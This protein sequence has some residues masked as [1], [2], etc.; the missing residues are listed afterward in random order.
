[1]AEKHKTQLAD[2]P[3]TYVATSS[4]P[5]GRPPSATIYL[6]GL[7]CLCFD[8]ANSC[9]VA[10][11]EA[12][13][14]LLTFGVW[15]KNNCETVDL[16]SLGAFD[17]LAINV[18]RSG[19][20]VKGVNVYNGA[21]FST[22]K[23]GTFPDEDRW[24]YVDHCLDIGKAHCKTLKAQSGKLKK[25]FHI[26]NGL[27]SAC[28]LTEVA[29]ELRNPAD[30]TK[31]PFNNKIGIVLAVDIFL[32]D[33]DV[34]EF[35]VTKGGTGVKSIVWRT[36]HAY[37]I[38]IDNSC[39]SKTGE[40]KFDPRSTDETKRNDFHW[41]NKAVQV[42]ANFNLW[43]TDPDTGSELFPKIGHCPFTGPFSD[44]APCMPVGLG[45]T[46]PGNL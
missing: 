12:K 44:R 16:T 26:G 21:R 20:T 17:E 43:S 10:V 45:M 25:R 32:N 40:C 7:M 3:L 23:G 34:I 1:M 27:F 14:H 36:G 2:C 6:H 15:N 24:S 37:E 31:P 18:V 30:P 8:S 42:P 22:E 13:N 33:K 28:R 39:S 11:A 9:T 29:F 4:H 41:Y 19:A 38:K 35:K 46:K 5:T